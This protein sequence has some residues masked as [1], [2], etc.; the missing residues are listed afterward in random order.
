MYET[1]RKVAFGVTQDEYQLQIGL[2][3]KEPED[4]AKWVEETG[5]TWL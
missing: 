3:G 5:K 1:F 2:L 4:Y